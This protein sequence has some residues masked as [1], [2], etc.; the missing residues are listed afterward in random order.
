MSSW[1]PNRVRKNPILAIS[2]SLHLISTVLALAC[3]GQSFRRFFLPRAGSCRFTDLPI[4]QSSNLP[5]YQYIIYLCTCVPV[6]LCTC[7]PILQSTTL[8]IQAYNLGGKGFVIF[9]R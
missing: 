8:P 3:A 9:S 7:V 5:I 1:L 2:L 4:Y 6:Y